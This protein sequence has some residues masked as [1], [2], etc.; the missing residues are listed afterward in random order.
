MGPE[1]GP[2]ALGRAE[3]PFDLPPVIGHRGAA[4]SAP[5]NTLQG[6]R[7]AHAQGVRWVEFDAKLTADGVPVLM[8]DERLERTTTGR[9]RIRDSSWDEIARLDAGSW[10]GAAFA[11]ARV[12]S[13]EEAL[14]LCA[15]LRLGVNLEIKPCPGREVETAE[16][17][18]EVA[19]AVWPED[20]RP[21][22]VSSFAPA[23][24]RA[25]AKVSP[26]WPRG[27]LSA[28]IS[29]GWRNELAS[30]GAASLHVDHRQLE[31]SR[32][33]AVLREAVPLL[34]YTVNDEPRARALLAAGITSVISDCPGRI[35]SSCA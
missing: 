8:H 11:G 23:A 15:D 17:V 30:L 32:R 24:L 29:P 35:L 3:L 21:P 26:D 7:A 6:I 5:E 25:A 22:L 34:V 13:L 14:E 18:L 2:P 10:F 27:C 9:G 16:R 33:D 19:G 20:R 28:L 31:D 12:P 4:A 1:E